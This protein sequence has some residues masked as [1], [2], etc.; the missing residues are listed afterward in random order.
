MLLAQLLLA[1]LIGDFLLQPGTWVEEKELRKARSPKLYFHVFIHFVLL[2]LIVADLGFWL[3]AL[4]ISALH[5]AIDMLKL[6]AQKKQ[7]KRRWFFIDQ[8]LHLLVL[9]AAWWL[10]AQPGGFDFVQFGPEA[11]WLALAVV[12]LT[13]PVA[14]IMQVVLSNF[15]PERSKNTSLANA[16]KYI[17]MLERLLILVFVLIGQ[18]AGVGFLLAA[19]S[20][21]R[22]GDL[23][24]AQDRKL[25]EYIM[26]GTL[27]SF[28]ISIGS[29][30]L[31]QCLLGKG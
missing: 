14:V 16:G 24:E 22:F 19:K 28:S 4:L 10:Y 9:L 11:I 27:M 18:W 8:G 29:A 23:K 21:F 17:G 30:L 13:T 31:L 7:N 26:I 15:S 25:T 2:M 1:H 12:F 6:Y 5:L 20:I 3:Y